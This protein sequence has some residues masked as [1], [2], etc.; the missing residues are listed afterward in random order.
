MYDRFTFGND[1]IDLARPRYRDQSH[2][3][4][5][6]ISRRGDPLPEAL[7]D[8]SADDYPSES[9]IEAQRTSV[10]AAAADTASE[11]SNIVEQ[12]QEDEDAY[13][14]SRTG[15]RLP[16]SDTGPI[17]R[18][19]LSPDALHHAVDDEQKL[20]TAQPDEGAQAALQERV[21]EVFQLSAEEELIAAFPAWLLK[22]VMLQGRLFLTSSYL[23]YYAF[24]AHIQ[25]RELKS[26]CLNRVFGTAGASQRYYF[27]LTDHVLSYCL[28]AS[29]QFAVQGNINLKDAIEAQPAVEYCKDGEYA[30]KLSTHHGDHILKTET[31][32][33]ANEWL[34]ILQKVIFRL[35][36]HGDAVK[37]VVPYSAILNVESSPGLAFTDTVKVSLADEDGSFTLSEYSFAFFEYT[38]LALTAL[39]QEIRKQAPSVT[40]SVKDIK[41]T[42]LSAQASFRRPEALANLADQPADSNLE[43]SIAKF[44]REQ[45]Q[46]HSSRIGAA[47]G[48][49]V[50]ASQGI[51][52]AATSATSRLK[53]TIFGVFGGSS[54]SADDESTASAFRHHFGFED[55]EKLLHVYQAYYFTSIPH[56]GELFISD[57]HL[58]FKSTSTDSVTRLVLP[59]DA[60][61]KAKEE[62]AF[63]FGFSGMVVEVEAHEDFS[64]EFKHAGDR[65]QCIEFVNGTVEHRPALERWLKERQEKINARWSAAEEEHD[66][67]EVAC[68]RY[69]NSLE[70]KSLPPLESVLNVPPIIFDSPSASMVAFKPHKQMHITCLTIGSRG[71]VQPYVA[72]CKG[73]IADGQKA[74][75]ATHEE[76]RGF[77]E[78]HGIEFVPIDGDPSELMALCVEYGMF[79]YSFLREASSKF[80]GWINDLLNSSWKACQGTDLLIESPSAMGGIHIAEALG[81]P[82]YRAFTMPW[83]KTRD[84]PHAF[85]VP[86]RSLGGN[87][88][89]LTYTAFDTLFWKAISGQVNRW[90]RKTLNLPSTNFDKLAQHKVPF[91][92]NFSPSVV[93][94]AHDWHEWVR[95]TGYWFLD[96]PDDKSGSK[97][98]A[99]ERLT[100]FI[101]QARSDKKKLVYIGFGSIVVSDPAALTKAVIEAV[102]QADV[103][104]ILVKGWS[105]RGGKKD[106]KKDDKDEKDSEKDDSQG[107]DEQED[108]SAYGDK[109]LSLDSV[110]HDWLFP[111][112]DAACHHGGAGSLGASLRAGVPTIV[113]PFFGDQFFFGDRVA[114]LGVGICL[115]KLTVKSLRKALEHCTTDELTIERAAKL[116]ERVRKEDGVATA[117]ECIYRDLVYAQSLIK[118]PERAQKRRAAKDDNDA[119]ASGTSEESWHQVDSP[120]L[121]PGSQGR[122]ND[123][124]DNDDDQDL[125]E[126]Q[127]DASGKRTSILRGLRDLKLPNPFASSAGSKDTYVVGGAREQSSGLGFGKLN[128]LHSSKT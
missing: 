109:I 1:G 18:E 14:K 52:H 71:D 70:T 45:H 40:S 104:C 86:D 69:G 74:R 33:S 2:S 9:E 90:R 79:T 68:K 88:N 10:P 119:T 115:K 106:D 11:H 37:V 62:K 83:V 111:Q 81:I 31:A 16:D 57:R 128:F 127:E 53:N 6:M 92:Y 7:E 32:S 125:Y 60:I 58:C 124:D 23:C 87:Y 80:R 48:T 76:F 41:D 114:E 34:K 4:I 110:P 99:P 64:F 96:N 82:Y 102:N 3:Y 122:D 101:K 72:L 38:Q 116:G 27:T 42:S 113:K 12:A 123:D 56:A 108:E 100:A 26:G 44:V 107:N 43:T 118:Y 35:R 30:F 61:Q 49:V 20:K 84:Y 47:A 103:R 24:I 126:V 112:I 65:D 5:D 19:E 17:E 63:R 8:R 55:D 29:E 39:Q 28:D 46:A 51:Q 98:E 75:I 85:A 21:R 95:V 73:L 120:R 121:K 25:E 117:I 13:D 36:N 97:W 94:P 78:S 50:A 93:P 22:S 91:L 67:L 15:Q 59:V 89:T 54:T 66:Q 105:D 77:V